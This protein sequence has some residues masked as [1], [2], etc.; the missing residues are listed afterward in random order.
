[1][2]GKY[3]IRSNMDALAKCRRV[4]E[5]MP[6]ARSKRVRQHKERLIVAS[7]ARAAIRGAVAKQCQRGHEASLQCEFAYRVH[8]VGA[9]RNS[10]LKP[11]F[12]T[13]AATWRIMYHLDPDEILILDVFSMNPGARRFAAC[14]TALRPG[15]VADGLETGSVTT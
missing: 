7:R 5:V 2:T 3:P 1:M 12:R 14:A 11:R 6:P 9:L 10:F 15:P 8:Y 13:Y 4:H